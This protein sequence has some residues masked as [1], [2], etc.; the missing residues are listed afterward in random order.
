MHHT[1]FAKQSETPTKR[2]LT[3]AKQR[4]QRTEKF[5]S[6][7][8]DRIALRYGIGLRQKTSKTSVMKFVKI[9]CLLNKKLNLGHM[10]LFKNFVKYNT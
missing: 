4:D 10:L 1:V 5:M 3:L 9:V 8:N 6:G 7:L 2:F